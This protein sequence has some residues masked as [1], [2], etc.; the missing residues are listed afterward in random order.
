MQK[1]TMKWI[2]FL[3]RGV[4]KVTY[5]AIEEE[6]GHNNKINRLLWKILKLMGP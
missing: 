5:R 4:S 3:F 6:T 1:L 2:F